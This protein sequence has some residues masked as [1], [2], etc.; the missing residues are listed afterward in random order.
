MSR[1]STQLQSQ[2]K[3]AEPAST[4][5]PS[6]LLRRAGVRETLK[7]PGRPLDA[8]TRAF[9]EPRLGH[10]FADVRVH[11]DERA[12]ASARS[13]GARA[14]TVGNH[15]VFNSGRYAPQTTAGLHLLAHEL[16]HVVQQR[17][18]ATAEP[19][20]LS[21]P[22]HEREAGRVADTL[23]RGQRPAAPV[24]RGGPALAMQPDEENPQP[25][26]DV[27]TPPPT[28]AEPTQAQAEREREVEAVESGGKK[29]VLYQTEVR[30]DGSSSWLAN[31]PGNMDYTEHTKNWG[32]Y[33]G[34]GLPWGKHNFAIFQSE[35]VGLAAVRSFL[36]KFQGLRDITLMMNMFAP[37]GD[38]QNDPNSY[39]AQVAKR[40]GVPV[41]KLVKDLDDAQIA[42]FALGIQVVEGWKV[43]T[44]KPRGDS[45]LPE[46]IRKRT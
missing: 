33:E 46:D 45:S 36:R 25:A 20:A 6:G 27:G 37:A 23:T 21:S 19:A 44:T 7:V 11:T 14:Y 39:A 34:K 4:P 31:N 12:V 5:A 24:L 10:N 26:G 40:L 13:V 18:S 1:T 9:V 22:E 41:T 28:A 2:V 42:E 16:A 30:F 3:V 38:L 17:G 15:V 8:S 29:Y 43:G 32:A 35:S